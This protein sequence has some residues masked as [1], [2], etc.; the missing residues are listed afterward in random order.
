[1]YP[2][3]LLPY[4][5]PHLY[6]ILYMHCIW[7]TFQ[8]LDKSWQSYTSNKCIGPTYHHASGMVLVLSSLIPVC[9]R[10]LSGWCG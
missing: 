8:N 10:T 3:F 4:R 1:V 5:G 7:D 9:H 2:F 6:Y